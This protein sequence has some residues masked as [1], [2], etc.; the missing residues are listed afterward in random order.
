MKSTELTYADIEQLQHILTL[1][2]T[3]YK[4]EMS[5]THNQSLELLQLKL[6]VMRSQLEKGK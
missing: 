2:I 3:E 6:I 5:N 4:E 1:Y